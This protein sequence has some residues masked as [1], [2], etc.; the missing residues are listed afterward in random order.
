MK[1]LSPLD[2]LDLELLDAINRERQAEMRREAQF[3]HAIRPRIITAFG[4][5]L[6]VKQVL[7][8]ATAISLVLILT[9]L[10]G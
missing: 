6:R 8:L 7:A 9:R 5:R 1:Q 10:V 4:S 3:A 2:R